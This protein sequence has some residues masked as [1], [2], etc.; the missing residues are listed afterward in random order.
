MIAGA[1]LGQQSACRDSASAFALTS[2]ASWR[3]D[4]CETHMGL[5]TCIRSDVSSWRSPVESAHRA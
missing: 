3:R 5:Y 2:N 1:A 4:R